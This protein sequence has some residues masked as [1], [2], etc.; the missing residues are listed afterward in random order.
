MAVAFSGG[1]DSTALLHVARGIAATLGVRLHALHV[2][3]GLSPDA[4]AWQEHARACCAAWQIEFSAA[5]VRVQGLHGEGIEAEARRLRYQAL[6][7]LARSA[8]CH[9]V[10]LAH[11]ADDQAETVLLQA[12]RGAGL[13]GLAA[14]PVAIERDGIEWV[15]PWLTVRREVLARHVRREGLSFIEDESNQDVRHARNRLRHGPLLAMEAAFPQAVEALAQVARQAQEALECLHALAQEDLAALR[16]PDGLD[17]LQWA[18]LPGARR[19]LALRTWLTEQHGAPV[20]R[21]LLQR[22]LVELRPGLAPRRWPAPGEAFLGC[23]R[24]VLVWHGA[25]ERAAEPER[26][27]ALWRVQ[28]PTGDG[29]EGVLAPC[30]VPRSA[31]VDVSWRE[32]TGGEQFQSHPGGVPRSLKKCFQSAGVPAWQRGAPLLYAGDRLLFVPALGVDA[33]WLCRED[34]MELLALRWVPCRAG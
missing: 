29:V 18:A 6:A 34:G 1:R 25:S 33:R 16:R 20:P 7:S 9:R 4:D 11:H 3:H 19:S 22:L 28:A 23:Y 14:M 31:L 21:T 24:D 5:R 12:L 32:R 8:G 27:A 17:V 26:E 13:A 30:G 10:L 15:R 2:H